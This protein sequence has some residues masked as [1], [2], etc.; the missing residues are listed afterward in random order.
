MTEGLTQCGADSFW[1]ALLFLFLRMDNCGISVLYL[2]SWKG[3]D[4]HV[5]MAWGMKDSAH[6]RE[7]VGRLKTFEAS[8]LISFVVRF[9]VE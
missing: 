7:R 6:E 9:G 1:I 3:K 8:K 4:G 2:E 5:E